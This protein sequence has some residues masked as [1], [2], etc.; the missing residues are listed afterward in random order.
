MD[1]KEGNSNETYVFLNRHKMGYW[2]YMISSA[3]I[4]TVA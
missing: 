1:G 4:T 2:K 3:I